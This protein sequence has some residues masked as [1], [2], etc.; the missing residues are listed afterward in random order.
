MPFGMY[1]GKMLIEIEE[2]ICLNIFTK[3]NLITRQGDNDIPRGSER[4][5]PVARATSSTVGSSKGSS[6]TADASS[7][8]ALSTGAATGNR[9]GTQKV[10]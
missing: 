8:A 7:A 10:K 1:I 6:S 5:V 2:R 4:R 9:R 3:V